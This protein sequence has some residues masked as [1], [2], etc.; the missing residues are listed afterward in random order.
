MGRNPLRGRDAIIDSYRDFAGRATIHEFQAREPL[1][2]VF[3]NAAVATMPFR[4][5]YEYEGKA[6]SESGTD[7]L[8][9]E[10][11]IDGWRVVWRTVV[12]SG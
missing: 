1:V 3:R 10:K 5:G 11:G 6:S 12:V 4:I 7:V 8:V 9:F 2:E